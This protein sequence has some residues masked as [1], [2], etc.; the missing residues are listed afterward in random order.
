MIAEPA[1][2]A[3]PAR[4]DFDHNATTAVAPECLQAIIG[5]LRSGPLNPSS[6]H[7][8]GE[9]AKRMVMEAR[10]AVSFV[11]GA[12]APEFLFPGGG[13]ESNHLAILGALAASPDR[14]HIVSSE[15]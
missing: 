13:T 12:S 15:V 14:R 6:K 5:C 11:F 8:Q 2:I 1:G 3:A 4:I 7:S 10:M 9:H